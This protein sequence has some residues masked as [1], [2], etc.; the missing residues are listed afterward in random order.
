M[1]IHV[2]LRK[3]YIP[4]KGDISI[5]PCKG[6]GYVVGIIESHNSWWG[7][8]S[9]DGNR[10]VFC[11]C[12]TSYVAKLIDVGPSAYQF[13]GMRFECFK[14]FVRLYYPIVRARRKAGFR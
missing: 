1:S 2:R 14:E 9:F 4:K 5:S 12:E 11:P 8:E 10:I 3:D 7:S 13:V 6:G